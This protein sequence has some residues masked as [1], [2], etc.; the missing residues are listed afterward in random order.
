M[1]HKNPSLPHQ[2]LARRSASLVSTFAISTKSCC[3]SEGHSEAE[4]HARTP[5]HIV[6]CCRPRT[7]L[8]IKPPDLLITNIE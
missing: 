6:R 1:Q 8:K 2:I 4:L 7:L 3:R 5:D